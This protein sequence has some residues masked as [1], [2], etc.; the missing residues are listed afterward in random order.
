MREQILLTLISWVGI[1]SDSM[2]TDW[3]RCP[4]EGADT[5]ANTAPMLKALNLGEFS[6]KTRCSPR[7]SAELQLILTTLSRNRP[8]NCISTL[9]VGT[10]RS[11][12]GIAHLNS[13]R[14][15]LCNLF[16]EIIKNPGRSDKGEQAVTNHA[17]LCQKTDLLYLMGMCVCPPTYHAREFISSG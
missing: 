8:N 10:Y 15:S 4:A 1:D 2:E 3:H 16:S 13:T 17:L 7:N 6:A 14:V 9:G 12:R 11:T 5:N